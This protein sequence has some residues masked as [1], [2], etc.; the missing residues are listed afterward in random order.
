MKSSINI[1]VSSGK[2]GTGKTSLA[3]CFIALEKSTV[4]AA[5]DVDAADLH[6]ILSPKIKER[7]LFSGGTEVNVN[8]DKCSQYG[9]CKQACRFSAII[10]NESKGVI[11]TFER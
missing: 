3:A 4:I 10:E 6:L 11:E 5:C 8:Q 7:G 1:A 2:G 9:E